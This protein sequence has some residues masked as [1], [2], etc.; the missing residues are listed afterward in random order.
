MV[1]DGHGHACGEYLNL[2]SIKEKLKTSHTD[3]V[4]LT[5]GELNSS[6]IYKFKDKIEKKPYYEPLNMQNKMIGMI[7]NLTG[8]MKGIQKGNE[9]IYELKKQAPSQIRQYYWLS[10]NNWPELEENYKKMRFEGI[11][12]HQCWERFDVMSPWFEEVVI[13]AINK[14]M[15]LFIHLYDYKQVGK[16]I[17]FIKRHPK[18]KIIIAHL[19]GVEFFIREDVVYFDNVFFDLSNSYFI[20][21]ER[22]MN[23]YKR[24]GSTKLLLGSDTPYGENSLEKTIIQIRQLEIGSQEKDNILGDNLKELLKI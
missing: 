10:K 22:I 9:Y 11:K 15:P 13:W 12:L 17:E 20:S 24:F 16:I 4:V 7:I 5:P 6:K 1:I 18:A 3:L 19:Y 2:E 14:D 23:A 21:K 8:A